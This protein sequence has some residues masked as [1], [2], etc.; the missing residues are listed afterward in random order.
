MYN[1]VNAKKKKK[2]TLKRMVSFNEFSFNEGKMH[3]NF[4][5][6]ATVIHQQM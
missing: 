5:F 4:D 3:T 1:D 2:K 6:I